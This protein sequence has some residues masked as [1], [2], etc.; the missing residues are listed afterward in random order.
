M[1]DEGDDANMER[2]KNILDMCT[3]YASVCCCCLPAYGFVCAC[4]A[5][6]HNEHMC[7]GGGAY[8]NLCAAASNYQKKKV[9]K[10]KAQNYN[11]KQSLFISALA[12]AAPSTHIRG[13]RVRARDEEE[14]H[15]F[16]RARG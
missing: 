5:V 3:P 2:V 6:Q 12:A 4:A 15:K 11:N 9:K 1:Y 7:R 13:P 16:W 8:K 10:K 14:T